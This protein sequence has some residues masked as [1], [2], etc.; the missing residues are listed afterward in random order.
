MW[1]LGDMRV[2]GARGGVGNLHPIQ[3]HPLEVI[4]QLLC[5]VLG[6]QEVGNIPDIQER[7]P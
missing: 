5:D 4:C 1:A 7:E 6:P 3:E 2:G